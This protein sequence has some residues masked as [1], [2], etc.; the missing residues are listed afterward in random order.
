M[1]K[2]TKQSNIEYNIP[3][4]NTI[5]IIMYLQP[6][7]FYDSEIILSSTYFSK[8]DKRYHTDVNPGRLISGPLSSYRQQLEPPIKDEYDAFIE[9]CVWIVKQMGFQIISR[10]RSTDSEKS[11]YIIVFGIKDEPCG[12]IVYD[13]RISDHPLDA[14][15]P[16]ELKDEVF[17]YLKI[18]KVL[19]ESATKAGINFWLEKITVG[20]VKSDTWDT[21]FNRLC[22]K[23]RQ[24]KNRV[25]E[26]L[27]K[28]KIAN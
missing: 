11:E 27:N 26:E 17:E 10:S 23:L 28:K 20:S 8:E 21:A 6:E 3:E 25:R 9:D 2:L 16:E 12:S 15:F 19:D 5:R 18:N 14:K 1:K 4:K 22:L 7:I 24:M 13:L